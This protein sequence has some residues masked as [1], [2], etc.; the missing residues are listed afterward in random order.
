[1]ELFL[2]LIKRLINNYN[3]PGAGGPDVWLSELNIAR[4]KDQQY[5]LRSLEGLQSSKVKLVT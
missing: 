5:F 4:V 3:I 2:D 1:M